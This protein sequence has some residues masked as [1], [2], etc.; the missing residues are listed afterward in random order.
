MRAVGLPPFVRQGILL[1]PKNF[2]SKHLGQNP[3]AVA[4]LRALLIGYMWLLLGPF[5]YL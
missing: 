2:E 1:A 3:N 4:H 5:H